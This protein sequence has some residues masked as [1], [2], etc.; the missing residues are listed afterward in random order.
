MILSTLGFLDT[1]AS[2]DMVVD[3]VTDKV[4]RPPFDFIEIGIRIIE[5][6]GIGQ[7]TRSPR[8]IRSLVERLKN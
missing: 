6:G 7:R 5:T 8:F 4:L 2:V 3:I 1:V